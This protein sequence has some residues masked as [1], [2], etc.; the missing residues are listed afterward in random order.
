MTIKDDYTVLHTDKSVLID[1]CVQYAQWTIPAVFTEKYT[2]DNL[3]LAVDFQM[4]GARGVNA[5]ANKLALALFAPSRPFIKYRLSDADTEALAQRGLEGAALDVALAIAARRAMEKLEGLHIRPTLIELL[6]LLIVTGNVL[7]HKRKKKKKTKIKIYNLYDYVVVRDSDGDLCKIIVRDCGKLVSMPAKVQMA[8]KTA[9]PHAKDTDPVE[10][11]TECVYNHETERW[12]VR[13]EVSGQVMQADAGSYSNEEFPYRVLTWSLGA[14]R[15]YGTGL[16]EEYQGAFHSL[17]TLEAATVPG[18]AEMARI[19]HL[20]DPGGVLDAKEFEQALS[21]AA[22]AGN[23]GDIVTPDLGGK[24]RDYQTITEK[25]AKLERMLSE[26]FLIGTS[27]VRDAE[28]VTAE[29][30]RLIANELEQSLGGVYSNLAL[31]LQTWLAAIVAKEVDNPAIARL[32]LGIVTGIDALS[33]TGDLDNFRGFLADLAQ[34]QNLPDE[35]K[36]QVIWDAFI[37][38][39]AAYHNVEYHKFL[40]P[41]AVAQEEEA[42]AQQNAI[43]AQTELETNTALVNAGADMITQGAM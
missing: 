6:K 11:Y 14:K 7:L 10:L 29:E 41:E 19:V 8:H 37:Q 33:Q 5:L 26:V 31:D 13:Q 42:S 1:R 40:K 32:E 3:E 9:H 16:I 34:T 22:L 38:T 28:R 4:I 12:T 21:G 25:I 20:V 2:D 18:L 23:E 24:A 27:A 35:V 30:I 36:R 15:T 39:L 17:S 43:A